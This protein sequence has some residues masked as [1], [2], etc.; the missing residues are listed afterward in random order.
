MA[1]AETFEFRGAHTI[2]TGA[3]SGIGLELCKRLLTRSV[4]SISLVDICETGLQAAANGLTATG[5]KAII[6]TYVADISKEQ[7]V[8]LTIQAV[9][10]EF[11]GLDVVFA[12]AGIGPGGRFMDMPC[13]HFDHLMN[14]NYMGVVHTLKAALPICLKQQSGKLVVTNSLGG[15][16]GILGAPA[17]CASKFATRGLVESLR[18]EVY[19]P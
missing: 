1:S 3:A 9:H 17:C 18:L 4:A 6:R 2:V 5:T 13:E 10:K 8:Q 15:Y 16:H 19:Q 7:E 11:G 14:V 12:N